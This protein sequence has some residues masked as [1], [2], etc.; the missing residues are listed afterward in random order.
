MSA[1]VKQANSIWL[2]MYVSKRVWTRTQRECTG[3]PDVTLTTPDGPKDWF[4]FYNWCKIVT[5][6]QKCAAA[7]FF[8]TILWKCYDK[9][10]QVDNEKPEHIVQV[11][12]FVLT[13]LSGILELHLCLG[14]W[15]GG[16]SF[17][18]R[19]LYAE[20][21]AVPFRGM[22]IS[23]THLAFYNTQTHTHIKLFYFFV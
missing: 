18:Y 3:V 7:T 13:W 17:L 2:W 23:H 22:C 15:G 14:G 19:F 4:S 10:V 1:S 11:S 12:W 20:S 5:D 21:W 9:I 6:I 8:K 16:V